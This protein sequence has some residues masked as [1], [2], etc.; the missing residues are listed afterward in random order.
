MQTSVL[1]KILSGLAV[2]ALAAPLALIVGCNSVK[3]TGSTAGSS[4]P[5][6]TVDDS[7]A[8]VKGQQNLVLA[9]GCFWGIQ[10]V[11]QHVKGVT[12][13]TSGYSGGSANTAE[14]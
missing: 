9:G 6:P 8:A 12:S 2:A 1:C 11:F 10:A 3:A 13:S 5:E 4:V 14:Y 7:L